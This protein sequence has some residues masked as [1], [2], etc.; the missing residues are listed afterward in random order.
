LS[1]RVCAVRVFTAVREASEDPG[2]LKAMWPSG[3]DAEDLQVHAARVRQLPLVGAAR[4]GRSSA[5]PSGPRTAPAAKSTRP[6]QLPL[7]DAEVALRVVRGQSDVLVEQ[8]GSRLREA[9]PAGSVPDGELLVQ[10]ERAGAGRQA[11]DGGRLP[12]QQLLDDVGREN[13][14]CGR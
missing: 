14:C 1:C 5:S 3:A 8:E 9:E 7:H 13:R 12:R 11:E 2:S 4:A 6:G 10:R